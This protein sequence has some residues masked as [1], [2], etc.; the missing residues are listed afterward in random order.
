VTL[1][2]GGCQPVVPEQRTAA[3]YHISQLLRVTVV[4][5]IFEALREFASWASF[6]AFLRPF[7]F[8]ALD[9]LGYLFKSVLSSEAPIERNLLRNV[10]GR[11]LS[12]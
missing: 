2:L 8:I 6:F 3:C 1:K 9:L 5:L 11:H 10:T 12:I 7:F 4:K